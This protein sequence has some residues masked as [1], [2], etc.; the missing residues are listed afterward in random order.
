MGGYKYS[1]IFTTTYTNIIDKFEKSELSTYNLD[2]LKNLSKDELIILI[3]KLS[4]NHIRSSNKINDKNNYKLSYY[5]PLIDFMIK[6]ILQ[7]MNNGLFQKIRYLDFLTVV[8][9]V[10]QG[11]VF[12]NKIKHL[13]LATNSIDKSIFKILLT[14]AASK[15]TFLTFMFWKELSQIDI[16][17]EDSNYILINAI[18][19]ADDRLFG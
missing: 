18:I 16:Y 2:S 13:I 5:Q 6:I 8:S 14:I 4:L 3:D 12:L 10:H 7:Y 9:K 17:S 1:Q 15:G 19:N 11:H